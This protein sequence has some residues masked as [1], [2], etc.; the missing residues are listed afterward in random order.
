MASMLYVLNLQVHLA[1][2]FS[3]GAKSN[4]LSALKHFIGILQTSAAFSSD[5]GK[6][7]ALLSKCCLKS[8]LTK[9]GL[10]QFAA[11][12]ACGILACVSL[13]KTLTGATAEYICQVQFSWPCNTQALP[14]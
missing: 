9:S 12:D 13:S 4:L 5:Q 11:D 2:W 3:S 7:G 1:A 6:P 10:L 14:I 8:F